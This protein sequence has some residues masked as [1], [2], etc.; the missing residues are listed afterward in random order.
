MPPRLALLLLLS[1]TSCS[2]H[3][4]N[5]DGKTVTLG[6]SAAVADCP[7]CRTC[8]LSPPLHSNAIKWDYV[9][10][11]SAGLV[12]LQPS[13]GSIPTNE[14]GWACSYS[15]MWNVKETQYV[16][17]TCTYGSTRVR[18]VLYCDF[19]DYWHDSTRLEIGEHGT[20]MIMCQAQAP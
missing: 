12:S 18:Q 4:L 5:I 13:G 1:L 19:W 14:P 17:A 7:K 16:E 6:A 11:A 9:S 3:S 10:D 15:A 2:S 20:V 8:P